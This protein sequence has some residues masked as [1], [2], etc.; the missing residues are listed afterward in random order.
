MIFNEDELSR[1][2]KLLRATPADGPDIITDAE[3][4]GAELATKYGHE[5]RVQGINEAS[6]F[7][8]EAHAATRPQE[9]AAKWIKKNS[10]IH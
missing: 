2:D 5:L 8:K 10:K 3:K 6:A 1:I 7:F 9:E 4:L